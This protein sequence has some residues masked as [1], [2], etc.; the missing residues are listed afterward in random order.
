MNYFKKTEHEATKGIHMSPTFQ[1]VL[2]CVQIKVFASV[3]IGCASTLEGIPCFVPIHCLSL[4][5]KNKIEII[6][7]EGLSLIMKKAETRKWNGKKTI[8]PA[9]QDI[10][11]PYLASLY[12]T[13]S[14][15]ASLTDPYP[16]CSLPPPDLT[17]FTVDVTYIPEGEN[18]NCKLE[19]LLH[20]DCEIVIFAWKEFRKQGTFAYFRHR[21]TTWTMDVT[22]GNLFMLEYCLS[23]NR[24][25]SGAGELEKTVGWPL[26][27]LSLSE[28]FDEAKS[29]LDC[30]NKHLSDNTYEWIF[31]IP[32]QYLSSMDI[33]LDHA[34]DKGIT[35][36]H[37]ISQLNEPRILRCLLEKVENIDPEDAYGVTPLHRACDSSSFKAAKILVKYGANVNAIT[38]NGNSPLIILASKKPTDITLMKMMLDCNAKRDH[39]NNEGMR[40]IDLAK[41]LRMKCKV[42]KLLKPMV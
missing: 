36:L 18:D 17:K 39:A 40:P 8:S 30:K 37:L 42:L 31:K 33:N 6:I 16:D 38:K 20:D 21:K 2:R 24:M 41:Q 35:L 14:L 5:S 34:N 13:Y 4:D 12:N 22:N 23:S 25:S 15:S 28:M 7:K 27:R 11:D 32:I 29:K 19:V 10:I 9:N 1:G 26:Q 3:M